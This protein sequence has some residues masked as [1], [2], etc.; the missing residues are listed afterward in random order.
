MTSCWM[1]TAVPSRAHRPWSLPPNTLS[2]SLHS[3]GQCMPSTGPP[4]GA[5]L[6]TMAS[7]LC[8]RSAWGSCSAPSSGG[9][10]K[11][12][13]LPFCPASKHTL[14]HHLRECC[15]GQRCSSVGV[16]VCQQHGT[17]SC[18]S[19]CMVWRPSYS[20]AVQDCQ[21]TDALCQPLNASSCSCAVEISCWQHC[22]LT[23]APALSE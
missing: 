2:L 7:D 16:N 10:G 3:S 15:I 11:P 20:C 23:C 14:R 22:L 5:C 12:Q 21:R 8:M 1:S 18:R 13:S 9:W 19:I 6:S 17:C 4:T